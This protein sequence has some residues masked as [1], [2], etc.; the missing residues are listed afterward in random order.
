M[1][2]RLLHGGLVA[3]IISTLFAIAAAPAGAQDLTC[4]G[5]TATI[6]GTEGDDRLVGTPGDDVIIAGGGDDLVIGG[7]GD[8]TICLG[9]GDDRGLGQKGEDAIFGESG[10]DI[11]TG[12]NR[13]DFIDGGPG[14]DTIRGN[15]GIDTLLGGRGNDVVLGGRNN[16]AITGNQGD[17]ELRGGSGLDDVFGGAGND[18]ILGGRGRDFIDGEGGFDNLDGGLGDDQI[19]AL[20]NESD[21]I[22]DREGNDTCTLDPFDIALECELGD[23]RSSVTGE[24]EGVVN[25]D[26]GVIAPL[27]LDPSFADGPYYVLQYA[28]IANPLQQVEI[29]IADAN[30]AVLDT[31]TVPA[32]ISL[33][34]GNVIVQGLP[35]QVTI[36]GAA[37]WHAGIIDP[38]VLTDPFIEIFSDRSVVFGVENAPEGTTTHVVFTNSSTVDAVA[39]VVILSD[40]G[41]FT[42]QPIVVGPGEEGALSGTLFP[43]SRIMAVFAPGLEWVFEELP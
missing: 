26:A 23:I 11:I 12:G 10:N 19:F 40:D 43:D 42:T 37:V 5:L 29:E 38:V 14:N 36:T 34:S 2:R 20:D 18:V 39:E 15:N 1:A 30:G 13:G 16:D 25:F 17:D 35:S 4:D 28:A 41:I 21:G 6:V 7:D 33:S 9:D 22:D 31:F 27:S 3:I 24:G 8:D 32:G